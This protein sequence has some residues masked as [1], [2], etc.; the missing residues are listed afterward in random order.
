MKKLSLLVLVFLL[1]SVNVFAQD[2]VVTPKEKLSKVKEENK[3]VIKK[4]DKKQST[5]IDFVCKNTGE[6]CKTID[7]KKENPFS[8]ML[9]TYP[10][11]AK[12]T[13]PS[14]PYPEYDLSKVDYKKVVKDFLPN[15][16]GAFTRTCGMYN[17]RVL[18]GTIERENFIMLTYG[19]YMG[20]G[21]GGTVAG[22]SHFYIYNRNGQLLFSMKNMNEGPGNIKITEDGRYFAYQYGGFGGPHSSCIVGYGIPSYGIKIID[23]RTGKIIANETPEDREAKAPRIIHNRIVINYELIDGTGMEF[24]FFDFKTKTRYAKVFSRKQYYN[25][26]TFSEDGMIFYDMADSTNT[27]EIVYRL[28]EDFEQTSIK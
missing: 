20:D 3:I 9:S 22:N 24:V 10:L 28:D 13:R 7:I 14:N 6:V 17:A 26:K 1:T 25:L 2:I 8:K 19:T 15:V 11:L 23:T 21:A 16:K 5:H 12:K 27:K 4:N 18:S